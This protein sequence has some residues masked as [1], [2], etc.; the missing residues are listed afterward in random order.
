MRPGDSAEDAGEGD[1]MTKSFF[2]LQRRSDTGIPE[3]DAVWYD[4]VTSGCAAHDLD[5][6]RREKRQYE[7]KS[8]CA[9]YRVVERTERIVDEQCIQ[10]CPAERG[11]VS[12]NGSNGNHD[13]LPGLKLDQ[14]PA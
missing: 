7:L 1:A 3:L 5:R 11:G 8:L 4:V 2:V 14:R 9:V 10:G 6:L 12:G 13:H